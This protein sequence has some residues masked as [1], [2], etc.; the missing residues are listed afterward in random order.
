MSRGANVSNAPSAPSRV[1]PLL[2]PGFSS[3]LFRNSFCG[4]INDPSAIGTLLSPESPNDSVEIVSVFCRNRGSD[5]AHFLDDRVFHHLG[6]I[7]YSFRM[8][9]SS[10]SDAM[11]FLFRRPNGQRSP[12]AAYHCTGGRLVQR[13]LGTVPRWVYHGILMRSEHADA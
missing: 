9:L 1:G 7:D 6:L 3:L 2:L 11:R 13:V 5:C 8:V 10:N 4:E 12:A